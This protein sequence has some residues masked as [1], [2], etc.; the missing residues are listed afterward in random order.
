MFRAG[1]DGTTRGEKK[2][3]RDSESRKSDI[4]SSGIKRNEM[5]LVVGIERNENEFMA[6]S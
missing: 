4:I 1:L 2:R 6:E 3:K 5:K